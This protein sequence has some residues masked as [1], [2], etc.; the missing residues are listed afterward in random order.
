[1]NRAPDVERPNPVVLSDGERAQR[2][3][4][5]P[6]RPR[7]L[8]LVDEEGAVVD[9]D[10]GH[11]M[12]KDE[13]ALERVVHLVKDGVGGAPSLDLGGNSPNSSKVLSNVSRYVSK[14][15]L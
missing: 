5:H 15:R 14:S 11:L 8:P 3:V 13:R 6:S 4:E 9:P 12:H 1:V 7:D 10:P 2:P